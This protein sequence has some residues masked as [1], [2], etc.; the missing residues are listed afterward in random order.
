MA[1]SSFHIARL[2]LYVALAVWA[3]ILFSLCCARLSYTSTPRTNTSLYDGAPFHDPSVAELLVSSIFTLIFLPIILFTTL[4]QSR[5]SVLGRVWF[6][7]ICLFVL[8]LF[9]VGGAGALSNIL[10]N[11]WYNGAWCAYSQCNLLQA[12]LAFA[13]LGWI[14][15]TFLLLGS[16]FF[17]FRSRGWQDDSYEAWRLGPNGKA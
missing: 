17:A 12:I 1:E 6:E 10:P 14:T 9:Y 3:F 15:I 7:I 4:K 5:H 11:V 2:V 8:W 13:W 16:L